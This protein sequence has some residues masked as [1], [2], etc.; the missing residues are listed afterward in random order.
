M[1]SAEL[2]EIGIDREMSLTLECAHWNAPRWRDYISDV[3]WS[4]LGV[5]QAELPEIAVGRE[6][7]QVLLGLL[8]PRLSVE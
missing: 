1:E 2:Y 3:A 7:F 8:P 4:R 5:E 6:V